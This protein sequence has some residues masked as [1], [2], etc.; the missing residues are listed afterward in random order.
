MEFEL[1]TTCNTLHFT[2]FFDN[3]ILPYVF[4]DSFSKFKESFITLLRKC[5]YWFSIHL[6]YSK[7]KARK[8]IALLSLF[9]LSYTIGGEEWTIL[10]DERKLYNYVFHG[11]ERCFPKNVHTWC[12]LSAMNILRSIENISLKSEA[13]AKILLEYGFLATT[14]KCLKDFRLSCVEKISFLI[15]IWNISSV[16]KCRMTIKD[17]NEFTIGM[18]LF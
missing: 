11:M 6:N 3:L 1:A 13:A 5:D 7:G 10:P 4:H 17:S 9:L 8:H 12:G 18:R 14:T 16:E 2:N 15:C